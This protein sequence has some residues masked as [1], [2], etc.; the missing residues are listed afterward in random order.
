MTTAPVLNLSSAPDGYLQTILM[1]ILGV[2]KPWMYV[3]QI[4]LVM[5]MNCIGMIYRLTVVPRDGGDLD[6]GVGLSVTPEEL[7]K[8]KRS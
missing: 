1:S 5:R 4:L 8:A 2:E 6:G 7:H 3:H